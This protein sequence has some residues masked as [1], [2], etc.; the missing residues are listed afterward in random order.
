[1][2]INH[3]LLIAGIIISLIEVKTYATEP[4]CPTPVPIPGIDTLKTLL[5]VDCKGKPGGAWFYKVESSESQDNKGIAA[6]VTLPTFEHDKDRIFEN[7]KNAFGDHTK[8]PL[9]RPSVYLGGS[10]GGSELDAGLTWDRVYP[11][12]KEEKFSFRPF[13]RFKTKGKKDTEWRNPQ[14]SIIKEELESDSCNNVL[15]DSE[16]NCT[17]ENKYFVG[18]KSV[19]MELKEVKRSLDGMTSTIM[20]RIKQGDTCFKACFKQTRGKPEVGNTWK[21]VNSIDQFKA[22]KCYVAGY[23]YLKEESKRN[24]KLWCKKSDIKVVNGEKVKTVT[25]VP[26]DEIWTVSPV[27]KNN[28]ANKPSKQ[29]P[30]PILCREGN[31]KG[32]VIPTNAKITKTNWEKVSLYKDK[33]TIPLDSKNSKVILGKEF[34][35]INKLNKA[36]HFEA[37]KIGPSG[38]QTIQIIP[39]FKQK[40]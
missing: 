34:C 32:S 40:N 4:L 17:P 6:K 19:D 14:R 5:D 11:E 25:N 38:E 10:I 12:G 9:D 23:K 21:R 35:G 30:D 22:G 16:P 36:K 1:M 8:G 13:W 33:D 27:D 18:G 7:S 37:T 2:K 29:F 28:K 39:N 24:I 15:K 26:C 31:E 20:M 3:F